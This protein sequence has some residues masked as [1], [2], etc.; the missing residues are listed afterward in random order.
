MIERHLPHIKEAAATLGASGSVLAL[1]NFS[2]AYSATMKILQL[3]LLLATLIYTAFRAL[4]AYADWQEHRGP[5]RS[6]TFGDDGDR[7][8]PDP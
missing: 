4:R 8:S 6:S 2:D 5:R 7:M 1:I 3:L